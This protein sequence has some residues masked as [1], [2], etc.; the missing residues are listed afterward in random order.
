MEQQ[1]EVSK[2]LPRQRVRNYVFTIFPDSSELRCG[3]DEQDTMPWDPEAI[4]WLSATP[5]VKFICC[6]LE[7][8]T[9]DR[10][11]WQG[12][13]EFV[14]AVTFKGAKGALQSLSVHLEPR[15]G[16][17][18]QAIAYCKKQDSAIQHE[19]GSGDKV[20]FEWGD[21]D[22]NSRD[23]VFDR[24]LNKNTLSEALSEI[25]SGAP[26][27]YCLWRDKLRA[28]LL[29]HFN[30]KN[31]NPREPKAYAINFRHEVFQSRK[32][33][34]LLGESGCGK[35]TFA[36]D[37]FRF[38]LLVRHMDDLK[39]LDEQ[40][41]GIVFDDLSLALYSKQ[42]I[43]HFMDMELPSTVNVKHSVVTIPQDMPRIFTCN[44]KFT[45]W[46]D[47]TRFNQWELNAVK[48]RCKVLTI[49]GKLF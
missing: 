35:T 37:H 33:L 3:L 30:R 36:L 2:K 44:M 31:R 22:D 7:C 34:V 24:A 16:S 47:S 12:Y 28:N 19:D 45:D 49:Y 43:I 10:L 38:P 41:D 29:H 13:I 42:H 20:Y 11:H 9:E 21:A 26:R 1:E 18:M 39:Q 25:E 27:D 8:T 32:S 40:T 5:A 15:R 6:G 23:A 14:N 48:R 17:K 4:D 46:I